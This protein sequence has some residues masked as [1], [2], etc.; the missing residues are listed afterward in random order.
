[1]V[2]LL[3]SYSEVLPSAD[4]LSDPECYFIKENNFHFCHLAKTIK[5]S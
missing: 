4:N 1:M 2:Q 5:N 3:F